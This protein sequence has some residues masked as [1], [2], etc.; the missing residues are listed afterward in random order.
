MFF[1]GFEPSDA[2]SQKF[3]TFLPGIDQSLDYKRPIFAIPT[4]LQ[5]VLAHCQK[6]VAIFTLCFLQERTPYMAPIGLILTP[7]QPV[8]NL[9]H[10]PGQTVKQLV[11]STACFR[12]LPVSHSPGTNAAL[13]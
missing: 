7:L 9:P 12:I 6:V 2:R 5:P 4:P 1:R 13:V 10:F 8:L 3:L 11:P